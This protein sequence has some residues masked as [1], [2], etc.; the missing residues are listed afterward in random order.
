VGLRDGSPLAAWLPPADSL[1]RPARGHNLPL[2]PS[3][4]K[5]L[6]YNLAKGTNSQSVSFIN[7]NFQGHQNY[8]PKTPT[9]KK[10]EIVAVKL[11]NV[12]IKFVNA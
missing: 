5:R 8:L 4:T 11:N 7:C 9:S 6:F 12:E 2:A 3:K 10:V 1:R